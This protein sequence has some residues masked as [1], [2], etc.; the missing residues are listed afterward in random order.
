MADDVRKTDE[1]EDAQ[2]EAARVVA[3][4]MQDLRANVMA[5]LDELFNRLAASVSEYVD[6]ATGAVPGPARG[7]AVR[8]R[9]GDG[10]K[11]VIVAKFYKRDGVAVRYVVE[12]D[13]GRLYIASC[14]QF[15]VLRP[16]QTVTLREGEG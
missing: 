14:A 13:S 15:V 1:E 7:T 10:F 12:S 16:G 4:D 9:V 11:G 2:H 5:E 3:I 6:A 8:G